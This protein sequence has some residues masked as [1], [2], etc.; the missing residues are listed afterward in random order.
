MIIND[1]STDDTSSQV[2]PFLSDD[3]ISIFNQDNAGVSSARNTG[4]Q[5]AKGQYLAFLDADDLWD[6]EKLTK[7]M[8]FLSVNPNVKLLHSKNYIFHNSQSSVP[9][10][11]R[12]NA[13]TTSTAVLSRITVEVTIK[14]LISS[15]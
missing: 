9:M 7:Q 5:L 8:N 1:G 12:S 2:R 10:K 6:K 15:L 3:R 4:I 14:S 13:S 11:A